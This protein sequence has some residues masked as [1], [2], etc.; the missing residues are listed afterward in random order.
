MIDCKS[1]SESLSAWLDGELRG[2]EAEAVRAHVE[3]CL[4][5]GEQRRQMERLQAALKGALELQ[6]SSLGFEPFWHGVRDRIMQ[7]RTWSAA[8]MDFI[9]STFAAPRL[10]WAI[11]VVIVA[12]LGALSIVPSW[13]AQRNNFASV[14]SI[15]PYGRNVAVLRENETRTTV[16]WLY[17]N[18]E[19]EN[20]PSSET[21]DSSSPSF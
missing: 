10:A 9:H 21:A 15:D 16:I 13:R 11:P 18:P 7:R 20:E 1:A 2:S 6:A 14:E 19:G 17:Q 5:C 3:I 8:A 4:Q 12:L